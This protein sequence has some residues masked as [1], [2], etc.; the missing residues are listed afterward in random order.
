MFSRFGGGIRPPGHKSCTKDKKFINIAI[1]HLCFIPLRQHF[2]APAEPIV[3]KGDVVAEGQ[4]IG[5]ACGIESANVHSSVPGRIA[6]IAEILTVCGRQKA[7]IVE[8]EGSFA[9]T[10]YPQKLADWGSL[11]GE[12]IK[13]KI[14]EAGIVGLGGALYPT[15]AKLSA[16]ADKKIETLIVNG[17]EC[18]P[19]LTADDM[20][21]NTY[22]D[23]I[24]EGT[25]IVMKAL[26]ITNAVIGVGG[27]KKNARKAI[28]KSLAALN[29]P[30]HITIKK[31]RTG[32]PQGEEKQI[33]I[34]ILGREVP[35]GG[36][37]MDAGVIVHN[38]GTVYA[39]REAVACGRALF[40]RHI[41]VSGGAISRP[42]NYKVRIGT[43]VS[44][45]IEECGGLKE[46][47]AK[48]IMGGPLRGIEIN[49]ME[50]PVM[51]GTAGLLFL[52]DKE[53]SSSNSVAC[54]RCGKCVAVCPMRLLP[55]DMANA[56]ERERF[57]LAGELNPGDC[58][59]C[60]SCNYVCPARRP[61]SRFFGLAQERMRDMDQ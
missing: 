28:E 30:E 29:P 1:P 3:N 51:K 49:S 34:A 42:G 58:V 9:S 26:N 15:A 35:S 23:A 27:D 14:G 12:D 33:I 24:L 31:L 39:I 46:K 41:T 13:K 16:P 5:K 36:G 4:L 10:A 20:L 56:V 19:Y 25:R 44:H 7:I 40:L 11:S 54:I 22:P 59:R 55:C 48:I 43:A 21:M 45:I 60:G 57:D 6:D 18:E 2:G 53:V 47:A 32:Y 8:A 50:I 52:T 37:P 17:A 61:L 38:A